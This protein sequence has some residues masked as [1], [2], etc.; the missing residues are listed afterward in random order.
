[1]FD[2]SNTTSGKAY[3]R[4]YRNHITD[5]NN[6]LLVPFCC[7]LDESGVTGNMRHPVQPLL[8]KCLLLEKAL[9]RYCPLAYIPCATKSSAE[10]RQDGSSEASRGMNTRNFHAALSTVF[11]EWDEAADWF[12]ENPQQVTLGASTAKMVIKPVILCFL[13]DHKSQLMLSC[14]YSNSTCSECQQAVPWLADNPEE[15][16]KG[17]ADTRAIRKCNLELKELENAMASLEQKKNEGTSSEKRAVK[18]Q[19]SNLATQCVR[20]KKKLKEFHVIPCD[21]AFSSFRHIARPINHCSPADHLHVFLLG[22][23]KTC[24]TCT[25]GNFTDRQKK[26]LDDLARQL[27]RSN[28]SS[29][30]RMFP[31]FYIEKG[32]TN[33]GNL[34]GSEWVGFYFALLVVGLTEKGKALIETSL[35]S[36]HQ[37]TKVLQSRRLRSCKEASR[38]ARKSPRRVQTT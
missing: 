31:R 21:N 8:V 18:R 36:H 20:A 38:S 10:N 17:M 19:L 27:F 33:T 7:W 24:A 22:V 29:A 11:K 30:R 23:L 1:M 2:F 25:I 6:E 5:P 16:L 34:T 12:A 14:S 28:S 35:Q 3:A 37:R 13:G 26:G 32:M 9:Q 4:A 15:E